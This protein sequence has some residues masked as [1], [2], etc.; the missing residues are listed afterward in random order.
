MC[1]STHTH[2]CM[3]AVASSFSHVVH[4]GVQVDLGGESHALEPLAALSRDF[5]VFTRPTL[6]RG[7]LWLP[8]RQVWLRPVWLRPVWQ[9]GCPLHDSF[10]ANTHGPAL[11]L[12]SGRHGWTAFRME[13]SRQEH[14]YQLGSW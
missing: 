11:R 10:A 8:Y 2:A 13:T 7:A 9:T 5:H 12:L 3:L 1:T 4:D 14:G 6:F